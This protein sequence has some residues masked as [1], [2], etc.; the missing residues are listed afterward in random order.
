MS[1]TCQVCGLPKEL[2]VCETISK[3]KQKITISRDVRRYGKKMTIIRGLD[4]K[5]ISIKDVTKYLKM[6]LACG[7]TS[8]GETIELQ[9]DHRQNAKK[10]MIQKGFPEDSISVI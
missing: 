10:A 6:K 7:G 4:P 9:G 3:E 5:T 8:K 1:E 2:C